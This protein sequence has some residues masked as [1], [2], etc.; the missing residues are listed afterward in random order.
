MEF[1]KADRFPLTSL[2]Y[3]LTFFTSW[4]KEI[5]LTYT[6]CL[7]LN[8]AFGQIDYQILLNYVILSYRTSCLLHMH[9][10]SHRKSPPVAFVLLVFLLRM[11]WCA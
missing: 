5:T 4:N 9:N 6:C 7:D 11:L 8:K 2:S 3:F 10:D 1:E